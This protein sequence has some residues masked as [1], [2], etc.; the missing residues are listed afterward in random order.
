MTRIKSQIS[1]DL[2]EAMMYLESTYSDCPANDALLM[3]AAHA[4]VQK[5]YFEHEGRPIDMPE[6]S[7][8]QLASVRSVFAIGDAIEKSKG[9]T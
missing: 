2:L 5:A 9:M 1:R 3:C 4:L 6:E 8:E 7:S